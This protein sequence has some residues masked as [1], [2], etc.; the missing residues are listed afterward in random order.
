MS[1]S[2]SYEFRFPIIRQYAFYRLKQIDFDG[3]FEYSPVAYLAYGDGEQL[4]IEAYPN[5]TAST[6]HLSGPATEVFGV[7]L[8]DPKGR[9]LLRERDL[10]LDQIE[11]H[12]NRVLAT[13]DSQV[14]IL[15]INTATSSS[16][17]RI[18]K[19]R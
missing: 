7:L 10:T 14:L 15:K 3:A 16:T 11:D 8:Y 4:N 1:R 13:I 5:P 12:V 18:L 17:Q 2:R 19:V 6:I 9:L